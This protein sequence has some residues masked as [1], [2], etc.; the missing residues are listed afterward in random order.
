MP[1]SLARDLINESAACAFLHHIAQ[2]ARK[3][4]LA[5]ARNAGRLNE[6]NIAPR[7]RPGEPGGNA[8]HAGAHGDFLLKTFR[9]QNYLKVGHCDVDAR[10]TAFR[11][12]H[13]NV[14]ANS[15]DLAL[16]VAHAGFAGIVAD[17][18]E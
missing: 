7:G 4:Q 15:A 18:G 12:A 16:K 3:D 9:P 13:R 5:T 14:T 10:G 11:D 6:Q 17:N 8:W 2:L 1:N